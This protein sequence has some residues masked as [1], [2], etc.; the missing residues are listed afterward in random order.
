MELL[1]D[2]LIESLFTR[3]YET[4][5]AFTGSTQALV[6]LKQA[7][8]SSS[9]NTYVNAVDASAF[10]HLMLQSSFSSKGIA[11][12]RIKLV[13][14]VKP[15]YA[16][17]Q[18]LYSAYAVEDDDVL[19]W[20]SLADHQNDSFAPQEM[21]RL[22]NDS[23]R[24][25]MQ[26]I[27]RQFESFKQTMVILLN[28]AG[29]DVVNQKHERLLSRLV[30]KRTEEGDFMRL[31][32]N[33]QLNHSYCFMVGYNQ[34]EAPLILFEGAIK[35]S[36]PIVFRSPDLLLEEAALAKLTRVDLPSLVEIMPHCG[37]KLRVVGGAKA[38]VT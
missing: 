10:A 33:S 28:A 18:K 20:E 13:M 30:Y 35:Q 37:P 27:N 6:Q 11:E 14:K 25:E 3:I 5:L 24:V 31:D 19:L 12:Q 38:K 4:E 22:K 21:C 1:H 17:M 23:W 9:L 8:D 15:S 29:L 26:T 7:F 34:H 36:I 2:K 16:T 32:V